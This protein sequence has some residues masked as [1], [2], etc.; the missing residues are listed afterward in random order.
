MLNIL[1]K[2]FVGLWMFAE[3]VV[4]APTCP[5]FEQIKQTIIDN[6]KVAEDFVT[7]N[8]LTWT[9]SIANYENE[10]DRREAQGPIRKFWRDPELQSQYILKCTYILNKN[11][12]PIGRIMIRH[13]NFPS[14]ANRFYN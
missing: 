4:A 6:N 7:I 11:N 14:D 10:F 5:D 3:S 9:I 13:Q 2:I 12:I 1:V 8:T